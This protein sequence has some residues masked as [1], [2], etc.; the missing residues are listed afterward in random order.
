MTITSTGRLGQGNYLTVDIAV[1]G[2]GDGNSLRF[3][4][5]EQIGP[6]GIGGLALAGT[7]P[8]AIQATWEAPGKKP[9]DYQ[10]AW[11][12]AGDPYPDGTDPAGNAFPTD[13]SQTISGLE[14]G[15]QYKVKVRA[16]YGDA[17]TGPWSAE[18]TTAAPANRPPVAGAGADLTVP[19][20]Q[21]VTLNGTAA[22]PDGDHP[23]YRWT[24]D[25]TLEITLADATSLSTTFT[26]PQ[27]ALRHLTVTFTLAATDLYNA[28]ASDRMN[29]HRRP[30]STCRRPT[31]PRWPT[32][33][34]T[35]PSQRA[36]Q[37]SACNGTAS[38]PDE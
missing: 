2:T 32:P 4:Q 7:A 37:P 16:R 33:G 22:D 23:T 20:G 13:T 38:D 29:G 19:E 14:E 24:H 36:R 35:R 11:A 5:Q 31:V 6:R 25:S 26:A 21:A 27:V 18:L 15:E 3:S 28:T 10:V 12:G 34:T 30:L 8:G 1:T 9:V 17:G